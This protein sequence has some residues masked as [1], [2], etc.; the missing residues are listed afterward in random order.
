LSAI[1]VFIKHFS[2]LQN[3]YPLPPSPQSAVQRGRGVLLFSVRSYEFGSG[4]E[5]VRISVKYCGELK[6]TFNF[7]L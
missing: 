4:F 3:K 6:I 7:P 5:V 2:G 1:Y